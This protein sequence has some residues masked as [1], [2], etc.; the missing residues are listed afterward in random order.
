MVTRGQK[1]GAVGSTGNATGEHLHFEL[2]VNG[3]PAS[4][5]DYLDPAIERQLTITEE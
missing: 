3:S 4:L 2:T 5:R 1:I